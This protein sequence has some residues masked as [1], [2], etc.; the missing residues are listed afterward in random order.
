MKSLGVNEPF[1]IKMEMPE[2]APTLH[3]AS[4]VDKLRFEKENP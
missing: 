2:A 1:F 3:P 4:K